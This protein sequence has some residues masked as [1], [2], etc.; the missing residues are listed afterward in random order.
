MVITRYNAY[1]AFPLMRFFL[2]VA[3][4]KCQITITKKSK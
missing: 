4:Y 1:I 3:L 2:E